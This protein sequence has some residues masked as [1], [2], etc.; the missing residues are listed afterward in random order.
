MPAAPSE[1]G[2]GK[3]EA[4]SFAP[5]DAGAANG[6]P[7]PSKPAQDPRGRKVKTTPGSFLG[8]AIGRLL[9]ASIPFRYFGA[10]AVFHVCAWIALFAGADSAAHFRGGLGWTLAALHLI[11]LGVLTMTAIGASLQLLPVATRQAVRSRHAPALVFCLYAPGVAATALGMGLPSV[12][13]L[14]AGAVLMAIALAIY[15][16]LLAHNL[17]GARGM[18][19]VIAHVWVAWLALAIVLV[20]ALSLALAY[21][22]GSALPRPVALALHVPFA[23]YGFMGMLAL[24]LSYILVPMFALSQPPD[25]RTALASC[26][27]LCAALAA[28]AAAAF[29]IAVVELRVAAIVAGT[30]AVALHLRLMRAALAS[31]MRR[32]LGPSFRMV[33]IGW[34]M[35]GASLVAA[36]GVALDVPFGGMPTLFGLLLIVG[37]LLT[38]LLGILQRIVPFLASMHASR[39]KGRPPTPS[40]LAAGPALRI[41]FVCHVAAVVVLIVAIAADNAWLVRIGALAGFVGAAAFLAFFVQVVRRMLGAGSGSGVQ[42][43]SA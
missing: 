37:W 24:G 2:P 40:S 10:A 5:L 18:P 29:G 20:A 42:A 33:R 26:A 13:L 3:R 21:A 30:V 41:H 16:V 8:G 35:L 19:A 6:K 17:F 25:E 11:T 36:L 28:V 32:D 15:A 1:P 22:G 31:G 39:G 7:G 12:P 43:A 38:F 27:L 4:P 9:P 14:T 34:V 23:A